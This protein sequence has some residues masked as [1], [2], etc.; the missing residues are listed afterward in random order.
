MKRIAFLGPEGTVSH[1]ATEYFFSDGPYEFVPCQLI[2]E[3]VASTVKRETDYSVIPIENTIDGSVR[4]HVDL[5]IEN[6]FPIVSEWVYPSVQN[7][8]G[9]RPD[10]GVLS[11]N[12][13]PSPWM[14]VQTVLSHEVAIPQCKQFL[15]QNLPSVVYK[16]VSST[17]EAV[18]IVKEKQDPAYAAIG[19]KL[20]AKIYGMDILAEKIQDHD[21]NYTRFI[22]IGRE[23]I[24]IRREGNDKT[25]ILVTLP[26]DYPG[27]LP[28]AINRV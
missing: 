4:H 28:I 1:E 26:E 11:D 21:N 7:L 27:A 19:T 10:S 23:T 8:I 3:V 9:F 6:D 25:T 12:G 16:K 5:L 20:A 22:A 14:N 15:D 18:R 2:S 24:Y 13:A 17:A